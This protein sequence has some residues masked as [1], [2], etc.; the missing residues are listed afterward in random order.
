[1]LIDIE[2]QGSDAIFNHFKEQT[3]S[4]EE[5]AEV[6]RAITIQ[7]SSFKEFAESLNCL[8]FHINKLMET[9]NLPDLLS[10]LSQNLK[11]VFKAENLRLWIDEKLTGVLYSYDE[12]KQMVRCLNNKG[13]LFK[14]HESGIPLNS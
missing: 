11:K 14:A 3:E 4:P 5:R 1:L 8:I 13:Y 2:N 12:K 7:F 6:I 9:S 10:Y